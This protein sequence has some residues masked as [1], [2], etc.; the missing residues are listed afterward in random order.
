M[1]HTGSFTYSVEHGLNTKRK[2][3]QQG[4][5]QMQIRNLI[6]LL[7]AVLFSAQLAAPTPREAKSGEERT[8]FLTRD[9]QPCGTL[10]KIDNGWYFFLSPSEQNP[11]GAVTHPFYD[12]KR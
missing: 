11:L 4:L 8:A 7:L 5:I 9:G 10:A 6:S 3:C 1:Q 12:N 2:G